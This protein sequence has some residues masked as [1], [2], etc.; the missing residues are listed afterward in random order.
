MS[1]LLHQIHYSASLNMTPGE[2]AFL[3]ILG[4]LAWKGR[5]KVSWLLLGYSAFLIL[6]ITILRRAPGYDENIRLHLKFLPNAG[7]WAG[8]LL[9]LIL[10]VPFGYTAQKYL[11]GQKSKVVFGGLILSVCCEVIQYITV[12]GRADVNDVLFNTLGAAVGT[13]LTAMV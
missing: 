9:N 10:Y 6:Y 4:I 13:W 12:R 1:G 8:N 5:R 11:H 3:V 7:I 2:L